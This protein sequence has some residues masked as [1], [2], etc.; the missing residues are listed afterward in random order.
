MQRI[1]VILDGFWSRSVLLRI[2]WGVFNS[3]WT[4]HGVPDGLGWAWNAR[5][6]TALQLELELLLEATNF[7]RRLLTAPTRSTSVYVA[8]LVN[9]FTCTDQ[10]GPRSALSSNFSGG[11][12]QNWTALPSTAEP[13]LGCSK[14]PPLPSLALASKPTCLSPFPGRLGHWLFS[15]Q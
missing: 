5:L 3:G 15:R 7:F 13:L 8:I 4:K 11:F 2:L 6:V 9:T 12:K 1:N 10:P 14:A